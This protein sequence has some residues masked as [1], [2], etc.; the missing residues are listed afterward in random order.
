M[1]PID[2]IYSPVEKVTYLVE[3]T[4]VEQSTDYDQLVMELW[5]NGG[6]TPDDAVAHAAK[7]VKD[8]MQIF[9]GNIP[10]SLTDDH[11]HIQDALLIDR[12]NKVL[13]IQNG[14]IGVGAM[15]RVLSISPSVFCTNSA[16]V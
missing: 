14:D 5:T 7:I 9:R 1:I 6:I 11:F 8:H 13:R 10:S 16:M 3:K 12:R 4:R 15:F 2:A